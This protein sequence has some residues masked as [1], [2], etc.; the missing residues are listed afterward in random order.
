MVNSMIENEYTLT[1]NHYITGAKEV[2][3]ECPTGA[4]HWRISSVPQ[5]WDHQPPR[6]Q[7]A[8]TA[9]IE[10]YC[11]HCGEPGRIVG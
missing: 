9:V 11:P 6:I 4:F 3:L 1:G 7:D 2:V 5:Y 8:L 10:S